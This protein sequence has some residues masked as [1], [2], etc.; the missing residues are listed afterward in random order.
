MH[1]QSEKQSF[2][3]GFYLPV[4]TTYLERRIDQHESSQ[5]QWGKIWYQ[6]EWCLGHDGLQR[7]LLLEPK[8][9]EHNI[10]DGARHVVVEQAPQLFTLLVVAAAAKPP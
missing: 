1:D 5:K 9:A 2:A 7:R 4:E 3:N 8:H 10:V 6:V